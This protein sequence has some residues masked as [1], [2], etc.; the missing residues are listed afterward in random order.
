[1]SDQ[2]HFRTPYA[3]YDVLAKWD[4]PSWNEATRKAVGQRLREVPPRRFFSR[5]EWETLQAICDRLIPQPDRPEQPVPIVPWIDDKL[6]RHLGDGY[7]YADM[8]PMEEAWRQGLRGIEAECQARFGRGFA[9]LTAAQQDQTLQAVEE[10]ELRDSEAWKDLPAK[11]FFGETLLKQV[12]VIYY[13]HPAAW[14]EI[15]HGGPASP[16]GYA[17]LGMDRR[18]PW[19]AAEHKPEGSR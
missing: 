10:G 1:V 3:G 6:H 15:G 14:S 18:D 17:R 13:S 11:R 19:E 2:Q 4:T 16:R 9:Q 5:A 8:P 12:V 7:R